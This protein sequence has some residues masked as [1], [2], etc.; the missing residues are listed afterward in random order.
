MRIAIAASLIAQLLRCSSAS[1][2]RLEGTVV[3]VSADRTYGPGTVT[4]ALAAGDITDRPACASAID[5]RF[6][7]NV[8]SNNAANQYIYSALLSAMAA[9]WKVN[10]VGTGA[11]QTVSYLEDIAYVEVR[12]QG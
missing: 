5:K 1:A 12:K 4:V 9:G 3:Y 6:V 2:G 7:L 8:G 11:C 10:V